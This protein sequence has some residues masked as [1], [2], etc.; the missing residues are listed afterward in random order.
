MAQL[1][2]PGRGNN[3]E[4]LAPASLTSLSLPSPSGACNETDM[5]EAPSDVH[6]SL[7][8]SRPYDVGH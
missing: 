6:R 8:A 7:P 1:T 2:A 3:V 5:V 4:L